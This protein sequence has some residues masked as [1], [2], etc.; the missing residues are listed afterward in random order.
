[1]N[2]ATSAILGTAAYFHTEI[3]HLI[4]HE[5][6]T[7]LN[8]PILQAAISPPIN[9]G[10]LIFGAL[11][12]IVAGGYAIAKLARSVK[13]KYRRKQLM[14]ATQLAAMNNRTLDQLEWREFEFLVGQVFREKGY[15]VCEGRG[16]QDGGI[17]I[18][19]IRDKQRLLVQC[20]HWKT[21]TV[22]VGVIRELAGVI[23]LNKADG[24]AVVCSGRFTKDATEEARKL[25]IHLVTGKDLLAHIEALA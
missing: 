18:T 20:K 13:T 8:A 24:G 16:A 23:L 19:L 2:A 21:T 22:G 9:V 4:S 7:Q 3:A 6:A 5:A 17:D 14:K 15:K 12:S 11:A 10:L 1:M 25:G